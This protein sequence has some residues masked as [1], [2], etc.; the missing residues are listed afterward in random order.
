MKKVA[1]VLSI[2]SLAL[3]ASCGKTD[4]KTNSGSPT[5]NTAVQTDSNWGLSISA[6]NPDV[7]VN[8]SSTTGNTSTGSTTAT[9][10]GSTTTQKVNG[11]L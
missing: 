5:S 7:K 2:A 6:D 3:L 8:K 11:S 10:S 4:T 9:G 1:I